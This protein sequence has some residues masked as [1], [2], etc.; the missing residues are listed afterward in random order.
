MAIAV[1]VL[2]WLALVGIPSAIVGGLGTILGLILGVP[3][4]NAVAP[5]AH[6]VEAVQSVAKSAAVDTAEKLGAN[7]VGNVGE[8]PGTALAIASETAHV[9]ANTVLTTLGIGRKERQGAA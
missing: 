5:I 8:L 1:I 9:A 4:Y 6:V 3:V 7:T 2:G